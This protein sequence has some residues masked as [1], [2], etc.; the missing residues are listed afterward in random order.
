MINAVYQLIAPRMI[1]VTYKEQETD[2][3]HV[4]LRPVKMSIC[5]ADQRYYQGTRSQAALKKKLPM[6]LIHECVAQVVYDPTGTYRV[7][8]L[9]I[10]VPTV[11]TEEDAVIGENYRLSSYFRSSGHDGFLQDLIT[12]TPD[13][14]VKLPESVK[15]LNV[16]SFTE[17]VS[18]CVHAA[19]RFKRFSHERREKIGI[20]GDGNVGYITAL[21][22]HYFFPASKLYIFGT[23]EEKLSYFSFAEGTYHVD[24]VPEGLTV[25]HAFECVGGA[26]CRPAINQM[27]DLINPEG[28]MCLMGVSENFVD[29]NTRM[30]LEK[31]LRLCGS[32]RS[33]RDDFQT[34]VDLFAGHPQMVSYLDNLVGDVVRVSCIPD[35]HRAFDLD[36]HRSFGK[37]VIDWEK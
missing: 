24:R 2:D 11:P 3:A 15:N 33:S 21:V 17:L 16:A 26:G 28:T 36:F 1:D 31:G 18:V 23:V 9:V 4:V 27:I 37:T 29:I 32:S 34:T 6:A 10:P 13:R 19:S 30:V 14:L 8:D 20:W 7:G 22:L 35:L 12:C 5:K 25:D